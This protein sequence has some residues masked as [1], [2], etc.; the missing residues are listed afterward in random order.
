MSALPL[1][2]VGEIFSHLSPIPDSAVLAN[3]SLVCFNWATVSKPRKFQQIEI[4]NDG[5]F[6]ADN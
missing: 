2:T 6:Y 1:E 4:K 5:E 3:C